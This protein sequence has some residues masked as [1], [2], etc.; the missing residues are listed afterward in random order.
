[1]KSERNTLATESNPSVVEVIEAMEVHRD[2]I[3]WRPGESRRYVVTSIAS[4][5][6]QSATW[7]I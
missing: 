6:Q 7:R 3:D 5:G 4:T 1:M 2:E